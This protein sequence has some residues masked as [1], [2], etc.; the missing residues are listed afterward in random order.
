MFFNIRHTNHWQLNLKWVFHW[1][2]RNKKH[3]TDK[4]TSSLNT[5]WQTIRQGKTPHILNAI[6]HSNRWRKDS[7]RTSTICARLQHFAANAILCMMLSVCFPYPSPTED[8]SVNY[9]WSVTFIL[10]S[11]LNYGFDW[12]GLCTGSLQVLGHV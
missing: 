8:T 5:K 2:R 12:A 11:L 10:Y 9:A 7:E 4:T 1:S 6:S 3:T